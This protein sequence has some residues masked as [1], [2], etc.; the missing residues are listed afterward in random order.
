MQYTIHK[1]KDVSFLV[2]SKSICQRY[3]RNCHWCKQISLGNY[4]SCSDIYFFILPCSSSFLLSSL[5]YL[6][7]YSYCSSQS[8]VIMVNWLLFCNYYLFFFFWSFNELE[9][10]T[11]ELYKCDFSLLI[12]Y[13]ALFFYFFIVRKLWATL[14]SVGA[15]VW[16]Q[17]CMESTAKSHHA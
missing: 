13:F 12:A 7:L 15:F 2:A 17:H 3:M 4:I 6:L 16:L 14:Y 9:R 10:P 5:L 11:F 1:S 8:F